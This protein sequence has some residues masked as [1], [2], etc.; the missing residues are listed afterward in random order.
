MLIFETEEEGNYIAARPSGTEP[1][2]KFYNFTYR[3][4]SSKEELEDARSALNERIDAFAA[5]M[6]AIADSVE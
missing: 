4:V 6:Q 5:D 1:K 3:P 2:V